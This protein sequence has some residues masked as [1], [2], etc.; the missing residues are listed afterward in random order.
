MNKTLLD[1]EVYPNFFLL[2]M[3]DYFTGDLVVLK[4]PLAISEIL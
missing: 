2:G 4:Y 3:R 1:I